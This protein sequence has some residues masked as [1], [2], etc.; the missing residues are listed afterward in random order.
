MDKTIC[1]VDDCEKRTHCRGWCP[2]HYQRWLKYGDLSFVQPKRGNGKPRRI[3][4]ETCSVEGCES[5]QKARGWCNSHWVRWKR[6]GGPLARRRGEVVDRKRI[7]PGCGSDK[8]ISDYSK[9]DGGRCKPCAAALRREWRRSNPE[10]VTRRPKFP[11]V[12]D[13]CGAVF[14]GDKRRNRYCSADCFT[15]Y[16]NKANWKHVQKRRARLKGVLIEVF[17]S[18]EIYERDDWTCL[19]CSEQIESW[20]RAPD[21]LA[22]SIDH[23]VPISRGGTHERANVQ[24][25]HLGCNSRKGAR[26]QT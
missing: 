2:M 9:S 23:I 25:A 26:I 24:A 10:L 16:K 3:G 6:Y 4:V 8:P 20:R 5:L 22:P 19:L 21:P 12:C 11:T 15:A 7:C 1:S 17:D 18:S 13:N 14:D